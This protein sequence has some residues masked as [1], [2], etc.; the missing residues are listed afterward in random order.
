MF[1]RRFRIKARQCLLLPYINTH[2]KNKNIKLGS[3]AMGVL[4]M[5]ATAC[6]TSS[7]ASKKSSKAKVVAEEVAMIPL[8]TAKTITLVDTLKVEEVVKEEEV[9]EVKEPIY[10]LMLLEQ[11]SSSVFMNEKLIASLDSL[12]LEE[13]YQSTLFDSLN[14]TIPEDEMPIDGIGKVADSVIA[15]RIA[16]LDAQTPFELVYNPIVKGY[17]NSYTY[18]RRE[19]M[20]RMLGLAQYYYPMFEEILDQYDIPLELKHLVIVESALNPKARSRVGATG[21]WQFMYGTGR[22]YGLKVSSYVDERSDPRLATDAAARLLTSYYRIFGDWNLALAAYNSGPG[23]VSK[24]IRRSGGYRSYWNIRPFLP[25]ETAGYVPAFIA[26]NYIMNYHKEH[27]IVP[28]R[29]MVTY[30]ETDT[31]KVKKQVSFK[32][33]NKMVD[34]PIDELE[35][36]NP[37]YKYN[38]IPKIKSRDYLLVL[39]KKYIHDFVSVEDSLYAYAEAQ[40]LAGKEKMPKYYEAND[41]IR[42][43]VR[44]GDVLGSIARKFGVRVSEIK[45]WNGLRSN[46]IRVGQR[47]TIYPRKITSQAVANA[48]AKKSKKVTTKSIKGDYITYTVKNGENLWLIAKKFPGISAQNIQEWNGI[49]NSKSLKPGMKLKIAKI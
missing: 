28:K 35:F 25:R 27:G 32:Q 40:R 6:G 5:T 41:R 21:L 30:Y 48:P 4:L 17:I 31:I 39:P 1:I 16:D 38:I 24:A 10:S 37:S 29:P 26:V 34:V 33:I 14:V 11:D 42:Y 8:D 36:L 45:R 2:M 7:K 12:W 47:L 3:L 46:N 13:F 15:A 49:G 44:S 22:E 18:R 19:Q 23:N 9:K 43:K 20:S